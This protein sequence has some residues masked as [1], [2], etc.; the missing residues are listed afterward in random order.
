MRKNSKTYKETQVIYAGED[1]PVLVVIPKGVAH[2]YRVLG[3]TPVTLFYHTTESYDPKNPDEER[4][5]FDDKWIG[6]D[7]KTKNR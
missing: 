4:I 1:N 7:W 6:F 5:D 2:G 3:V